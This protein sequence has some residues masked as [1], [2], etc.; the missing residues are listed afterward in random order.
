[1]NVVEALRVQEHWAE[2]KDSLVTNVN[3]L[4]ENVK[5]KTTL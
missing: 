4:R 3:L 1:M 5:D 2:N